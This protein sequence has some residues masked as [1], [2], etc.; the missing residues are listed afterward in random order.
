MGAYTDNANPEDKNKIPIFNAGTGKIEQVDRVVKSP[1][2]WKNFLTSEQY[3][4]TRQKGTEAP[5]TGKC[6]IGK[7]GGI[8][9]CVCCGTDLFGVD[10]KFESGTGWPS[11]F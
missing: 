11:F 1:A 10:D 9:R 8:Y 7:G 2:E 3:R 6:E 4:V 5:F